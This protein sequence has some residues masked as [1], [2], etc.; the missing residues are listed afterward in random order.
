MPFASGAFT[1]CAR[2]VLKP[3]MVNGTVT[4]KLYH[5]AW[6]EHVVRK[7]R[8]HLDYRQYMGECTHVR[9]YVVC[10]AQV[11][12][13][14]NHWEERQGRFA[15]SASTNVQIVDGLHVLVKAAIRA[16]IA[17]FRPAYDEASQSWE[18]GRHGLRIS[19]D[20]IAAVEAVTAE[21][22]VSSQTQFLFPRCFLLVPPLCL[23]VPTC[24][25]APL[26]WP[27]VSS[28][29]HLSAPDTCVLRNCGSNSR[30]IKDSAGSAT[31]IAPLIHRVRVA[32]RL[33][34]H[35]LWMPPCIAPALHCARPAL[36]A[37]CRLV[38]ADGVRSQHHVRERQRARLA[39]VQLGIRH[40][41]LRLSCAALLTAPAALLAVPVALLAV[42]AALLAVPV[43]L[44]AVP[45]ALLAVP[46]AL[47][48]VPAAP[49][50]VPAALLDVPAALLAVPAALLAVPAAVLAVPV[51]LLAVP[52]ALLAVP[53]TLLFVA[54]VLL[55][56]HSSALA[57]LSSLHV[58]LSLSSTHLLAS[59][60]TCRHV[61]AQGLC[62][63]H[64]QQGRRWRRVLCLL[65]RLRL[66][67]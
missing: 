4:L 12:D 3:R 56:L 39:C 37:R 41:T 47:L 30:C 64:V 62:E 9:V 40:D 26:T 22:S 55:A 16:A 32:L 29:C 52:A 59:H 51:A 48:A 19:E 17:D 46:A 54:A 42:P 10:R 14:V 53:A 8:G 38:R 66:T 13:A 57:S 50:A 67:A 49:L 31:C 21:A 35:H 15:N 27:H 18:W 5:V 58:P 65:P 45:V 24:L 36:R 6:L 7:H 20:G 34:T 23:H 11:T 28:T 61:C 60:G 43:A 33:P 44:L 63:S 1:A 2:A 25:H